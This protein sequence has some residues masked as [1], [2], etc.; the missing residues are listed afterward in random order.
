M[1][2]RQGQLISDADILTAATTLEHDRT[3]VTEH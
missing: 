2:Y 3:M 1:L